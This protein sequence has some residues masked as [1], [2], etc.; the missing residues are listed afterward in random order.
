DANSILNVTAVEKTSGEK[1]SITIKSDVH[2]SKN[3]IEHMVKE[4]EKFAEEDRKN[5]EKIE[6]KNQLESYIYQVKNSLKDISSKLDSID[7]SLIETTI[8]QTLDWL[9]HHQ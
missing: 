3:E 8:Q 2:R 5:S 7:A 4:A 9:T 1:M 6:S